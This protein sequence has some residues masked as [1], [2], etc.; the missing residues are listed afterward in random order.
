MWFM[1]FNA[2]SS[3]I[4]I[5]CVKELNLR[6]VV[7]AAIV[8]VSMGIS[9]IAFIPVG[10]MA[11][12]IGR[13]KSIIVGFICATIAFL[14]IFIPIIKKASEKGGA[15]GDAIKATLFAL[16]YLVASFGLIIANVNTFPMV[17]E[18]SSEGSIGKYT[19]YYYAATMSAQ[20]ITPFIAGA[21]M[22]KFGSKFLFLY[23][24]ICVFIAIII[25]LFVRYGDG[26]ILKKGK[27]LTKEE[28]KE[29]LLESMGDAD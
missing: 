8:G 6:P 11:T 25:M 26:V 12:R 17:V 2:V 29:V 3:N 10:I 23:S 4:S 27:K 18:L 9:A 21:V 15:S 16:F 1:G 7:A 28:K 20:A 13:R 19:G 14:L 5:Y 24:A 22:D